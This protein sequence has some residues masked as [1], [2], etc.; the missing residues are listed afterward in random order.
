VKDQLVIFGAELSPTA[1]EDDSKLRQSP[2][3]WAFN[4]LWVRVEASSALDGEERVPLA[5]L[6]TPWR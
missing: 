1:V 4:L 3:S 5:L 6:S 2:M